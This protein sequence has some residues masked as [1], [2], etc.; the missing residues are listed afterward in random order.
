MHKH[1]QVP[2]MQIYYTYHVICHHQSTLP[3]TNMDTQND[4]LEK[5]TPFENGNCWH[6]CWISGVYSVFLITQQ[7]QQQQQQQ[8]SQHFLQK[9]Q[10]PQLL[11]GSNT[12][13]KGAS[14][15]DMT[16]VT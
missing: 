8:P 16:R 3:N 9:S 13:R 11:Q 10:T 12:R 6:L 2:R 5:V 15:A 1:T 4:G 14:S 7:Q